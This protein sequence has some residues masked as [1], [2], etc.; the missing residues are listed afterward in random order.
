MYICRERNI[1]IY[2]YIYIC[3]FVCVCVCVCVCREGERERMTGKDTMHSMY[4]HPG[5]FVPSYLVQTIANPLNKRK[6]EH[7]GKTNLIGNCDTR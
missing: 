7:L 1:Y 6:K 5:D 2:I 3:V 4:A